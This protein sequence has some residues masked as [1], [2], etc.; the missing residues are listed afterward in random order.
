M[1]TGRRERKKLATRAAL[2]QAALRLALR[3]G[4]EN[5]TAERIADEADIARRTFFNYF[6]GKEEALLATAAVGAEAVVARF[7]ARPPEE[8]VLHALRE[9]VLEVMDRDDVAGHEHVAVL[10][11]A[12]AA[13]SLLP[14]QLSV[15]AAQ[16]KALAAAIGSR[17]AEPDDAYARLC[18]TVAFATLRLTLDRWLERSTGDDPPP[19]EVLR[20]EVA[21]AFAT[22]AAGLDR[23]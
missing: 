20:A 11:L 10:R 17:L 19:L 4:V 9:A 1:E 15:L 5:V 23:P 14:Q 12:R 16:E 7:R 2:R 3:D 8:S 22:L 13:P 21:T 6:S 18:A